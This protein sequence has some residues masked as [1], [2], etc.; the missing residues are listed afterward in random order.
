M[1]EI[2]RD[3]RDGKIEVGASV[4]NDFLNLKR[5]NLETGEISK[6]EI[7]EAGDALSFEFG[8]HEKRISIRPSGTEP[9]MKI[10]AQW[11][12]EKAED[13]AEIERILQEF[14]EKIL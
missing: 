12:F 13:R 14:K 1:R 10:Y 4:I 5:K 3:L 9:K 7:M 8:A 6:I 11:L 2:M